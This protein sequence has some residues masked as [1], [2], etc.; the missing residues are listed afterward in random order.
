MKF[1]ELKVG[2]FFIEDANRNQYE[3]GV[4]VFLKIDDNW[5]TQVNS[6]F[7]HHYNELGSVLLP[8]CF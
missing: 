6:G 1:Q 2:K 8:L 4:R 7:I 5:C 3:G